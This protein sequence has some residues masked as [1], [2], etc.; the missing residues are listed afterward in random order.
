MKRLA[1]V[2]LAV[3]VVTG[4]S[5]RSLAQADKRTGSGECCRQTSF[6]V[7]RNVHGR[8]GI[9]VE[10]NG[11]VDIRTKELLST[12]GDEKLDQ[13]IRAAGR[14]FD[15]EVLGDFVVCPTSLRERP[16]RTRDVQAVCV[17]S[18]KNTKVVKNTRK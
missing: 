15:H 3:L 6:G 8:Y 16:E 7:C 4:S 2:I 9:Y 14:E 1:L 13:M 18:F 10:N 5:N 17:Q 12:P 11:I